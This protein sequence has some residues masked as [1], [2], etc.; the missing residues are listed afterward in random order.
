MENFAEIKRLT[1]CARGQ[2]D[3]LEN[4]LVRD[5]YSE[6]M[7]VVALKKENLKNFLE[8][9]RR[10]IEVV[11]FDSPSKPVVKACNKFLRELLRISENLRVSYLFPG[12]VES[13]YILD[14]IKYTQEEHDFLSKN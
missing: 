8:K 6:C 14:T 3:E 7:N 5:R 1:K 4:D 11:L 13:F 9:I 2:W 10:K 12:Y